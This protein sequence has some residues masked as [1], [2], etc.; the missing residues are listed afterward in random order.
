MSTTIN[1]KTT[2]RRELIHLQKQYLTS[3]DNKPHYCETYG[4]KYK[5]LGIQDYA[6]YAVLRGKDWRKTSHLSDGAN[7]RASLET[8]LKSCRQGYARF[9][10]RLL[11]DKYKEESDHKIIAEALESM[12]EAA[13]STTGEAS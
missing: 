7:A 12:L 11:H 9:P 6:L 3:S 1:T 10:A 2:L 13:L 5:A 8:L 4:T